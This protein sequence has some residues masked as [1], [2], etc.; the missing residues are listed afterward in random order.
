MTL[1][2]LILRFQRVDSLGIGLPVD[3]VLACPSFVQTLVDVCHTTH[4]EAVELFE[5]LEGVIDWL[6]VGCLVELE[7]HGNNL[8]S[9]SL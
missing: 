7:H 5:C 8:Q 3:R 9:M 6:L 2:I 4:I 1:K